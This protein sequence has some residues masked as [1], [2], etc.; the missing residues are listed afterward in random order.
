MLISSVALSH[1]TGLAS[2][3]FLFEFWQHVVYGND[4]LEQD[5]RG[6]SGAREGEVEA[7]CSGPRAPE[8]WGARKGGREAW[9]GLGS[10]DIEWLV[11]SGSHEAGRAREERDPEGGTASRQFS[12][13]GAGGRHFP[14]RGVKAGLEDVSAMSPQYTRRVGLGL[15]GCVLSCRLHTTW[16][17]GI[18]TSLSLG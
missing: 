3:S 13:P 9:R 14:S 8:R 18:L 6:L 7:D 1:L 17:A 11:G 5:P 15:P 16:T 10:K 12:P 2:P 4:A